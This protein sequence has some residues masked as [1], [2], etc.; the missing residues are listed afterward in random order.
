MKK[1]ITLSIAVLLSL[2]TFAT[3]HP[4]RD[5]PFSKVVFGKNGMVTKDKELIKTK[6]CLVG[7][8]IGMFATGLA[9]QQFNNN[10]GRSF[11]GPGF[12]IGPNQLMQGVGLGMVTIGIVI[13][14]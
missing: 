10:N 11:Q 2:S 1:I 3:N 9:I 14:F 6:L 7:A 8:G 5:T 12:S 4:S 13:K